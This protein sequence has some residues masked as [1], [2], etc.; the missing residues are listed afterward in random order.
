[1][2]EP[3]DERK[4]IVILGGGLSGLAAAYDLSQA[5]Q[6]VTLLEKNTDLGGLASSLQIQGAWVER[7]YH[8]ICRSDHDLVDFVDQ[9]GLGS[10]LHWRQTNTSFFHNARHYAFGTPFDLLFFSAVP[11]L[12]R[13]RFGLHIIRSRY[14]THWHWLDQ[15]PAKP[16]LI[17]T[18]GEQA[19]NVIWHPLLQIK[20]GE[21]HDQIS[22]AWV[23]HRIWRVAKSRRRLWEHEFFG[24]LEDG[25]ATLV[26]HLASQLINSPGV[27]VL[28]GVA[29]QQIELSGGRVAAVHST[30]G[31]HE[32]DAVL[33]TL[34]LPVLDRLLPHLDLPYFGRL[35]Q[36]QYIGVVCILLSLKQSFSRNFWMNVNDPHISFN[37]V[38]EQTNL[39]RHLQQAGLNLIY[40]P[41][42]LPISHPR[43][44]FD[45]ETLFQECVPM[46]Q[47]VRPDFAESWIQDRFVFRS[48]YA[49]AI[50]TTGF[51]ELV[52]QVRTPLTGLYLTDSTQ[53]YPE[54]RTL[55]AAIRQGRL[56]ARL[57]L[58]DSHGAG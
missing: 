28:S 41:F 3:T 32:C 33:S 53:Y 20:F 19:Y 34:A 24:Y 37:G 43:Y 9:L 16:W 8:F 42:Y 58:E 40:I 15:M 50:C 38:I 22:A 56:A 27:R 6:R 18:I 17:E 35:R 14:R 45:D 57:F 13:L 52:P 46:L 23:W 7:F 12:Q 47:R 2:T 26:N 10:R 21:Y 4:H 55:S 11:W 51:S 48:L 49:Q 1:M 25:S 5:G 39:N 36:I 29:A 31:R 54:D 30:A 44:Q